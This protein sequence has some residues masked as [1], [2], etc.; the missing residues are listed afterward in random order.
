MLGST[1]ISY[2][3]SHHIYG[4]SFGQNVPTVVDK[5]AY[6]ILVVHEMV[7]S[8]PLFPKQKIILP[9]DIAKTFS[10]YSLI[11]CGDY[12]YRFIKDFSD[13]IVCNP[14]AM[15]RLTISEHD[16]AH[17]PGVLVIDTE[18]CTVEE[19]LLKVVPAK[20]IFDLSRKPEKVTPELDRESLL[21]FID[22]LKSAKDHGIEWKRI[23]QEVLKRRKTSRR[24]CNLLDKFCAR[25]VKNG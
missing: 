4:A 16:L 1:P 25:A 10:D 20:D 15:M 7:T 14:G 2:D 17:N 19:H 24:I 13:C 18:K 11:I 9:K 23:L 22:K 6:N 5:D 3:S 8:K 12:H 21:L